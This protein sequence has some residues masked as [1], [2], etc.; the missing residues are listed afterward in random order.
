MRIQNTGVAES[1][2]M[3]SLTFGFRRLV[4]M[5]GAGLYT[6]VGLYTWGW[7]LYLRLV[8]IPGVGLFI[9]GVGLHTLG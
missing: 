1:A 6:G 5:P 8:F 2:G 3:L 9:T 4:F 7:F